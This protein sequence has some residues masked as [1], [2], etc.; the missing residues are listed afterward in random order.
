MP[1]NQGNANAWHV[2]VIDADDAAGNVVKNALP[3]AAVSWSGGKDSCLAFHRMRAVFNVQVLVTMLTEDGTR[4]RSHGLRPEIIARQAALLDLELFTARASWQTYEAEFKRTLRQLVERGISHVVF[5]D[6][7]LDASK[8]WA[9]RVCRECGLEAVE[10]LWGLP[11]DDLFTNF[12]RIGGEAVIVATRAALL[13]ASWLNQTL[14]P[15][16]LPAFRALGVDAC[17]ERGEYHTLVVGFP[18][19]RS[20]LP[21]CERGRLLHNGYWLL[22][23]ELCPNDST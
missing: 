14:D 15:S 4:T 6:I 20:R 13:D 9:D 12:I 10:P 23:L 1:A 18:S 7:F 16:M 8:A 2:Q 22:D 5:G 3:R 21:I 19:V 11:T 17:G